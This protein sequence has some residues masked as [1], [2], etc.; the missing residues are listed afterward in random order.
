MICEL[1]SCL[2]CVQL[3][4]QFKPWLT[5][6]RA[7]PTSWRIGDGPTLC[8][9]MRNCP[10]QNWASALRRSKK[11]MK[12]HPDQ[13]ETDCKDGRKMD[14][15]EPNRWKHHRKTT[16]GS[17]RSHSTDLCFYLSKFQQRDKIQ[18]DAVCFLENFERISVEWQIILSSPNTNT[19]IFFRWRKKR[20]QVLLHWDEIAVVG[21][22]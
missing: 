3:V 19:V 21:L 6:S 9:R 2:Q 7:Y 5:H 20:K 10:H 1:W 13:T 15:Q 8:W 11:R 22:L 14:S 17:F 4:K 18:L 12:N 16:V